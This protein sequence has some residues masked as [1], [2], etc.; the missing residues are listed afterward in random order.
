[1]VLPLAEYIFNSGGVVSTTPLQS[2]LP[3]AETGTLLTTRLRAD[4]VPIP[5]AQHRNSLSS[6][7]HPISSSRSVASWDN[8]LS[9]I[10]YE[11][12]EKEHDM[13]HREGGFS[14]CLPHHPHQMTAS[15]L[16]PSA[17]HRHTPSTSSAAS[18]SNTANQSS[19][20]NNHWGAEC[21]ENRKEDWPWEFP[22]TKEG[23]CRSISAKP[24]GINKEKDI[25]GSS[26]K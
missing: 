5:F 24:T 14:Y 9:S 13:L 1:M 21:I 18:S 16:F 10:F 8:S 4:H 12:V 23:E 3:V 2:V 20:S 7:H 25:H 19:S 6:G 17:V 11:A 26:E 22:F 15:Q